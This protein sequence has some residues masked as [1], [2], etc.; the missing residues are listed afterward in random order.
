ME[1]GEIKELILLPQQAKLS[2]KFRMRWTSK[3]GYNFNFDCVLSL[4]NEGKV[5]VRAPFIKAAGRAISPIVENDVAL[6]MRFNQ[7][8]AG[9]YA[10]RGILVH[11]E[12]ELDL[13]IIKTGMQLHGADAY[14]ANFFIQKILDEKL[15][16]NFS[17]RTVDESRN[18]PNAFDR[19]IDVEL[20]FGGENASIQNLRL[21][22]DKWET[23]QMMAT[24]LK[25]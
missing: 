1:H 8:G 25:G 24:A 14:D 2:L 13:A 15:L 9:V 17:I 5:S 7:N 21:E 4:R 20:S 3:M 19:P 22:L 6:K 11:V 10:D 23:F 12:D 16:S 18:S